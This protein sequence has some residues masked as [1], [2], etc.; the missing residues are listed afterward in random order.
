MAASVIHKELGLCVPVDLS[1]DV[2]IIL[3]RLL[4]Y[5]NAD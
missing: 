5:Y 3:H 4:T 2:S 1:S